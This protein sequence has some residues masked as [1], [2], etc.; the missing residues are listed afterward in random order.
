MKK[1]VS[2]SNLKGLLIFFVVF[3]HMLLAIRNFDSWIIPAIYSFHM[4]AFAFINGLLSKRVTIK[5]ILNLLILYVIFQLLICPFIYYSGYYPVEFN[6]L[7]PYYHLWYLLT[8]S[9]WYVFAF[10][11]TK[12][13]SIHNLKFT[14]F[15]YLFS[16][17][18]TLSIL[19]LALTIRYFANTWHFDTRMLSVNRTFVFF[20]FFILGFFLNLDRFLEFTKWCRSKKFI[21]ITI[22]IL[23][24]PIAFLIT[25]N[26]IVFEVLFYG[27]TPASS[28]SYDLN[29]YLI[30]MLF[31]YGLATLITFL[32]FLIISDKKSVF[33]KI[34]ENSMSIY[35]LHPFITLIFYKNFERFATMNQTFVL[36]ATAFVSFLICYL[37][38]NR[39]FVR[40]IQKLNFFKNR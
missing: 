20:P 29:N 7:Q 39:F 32:L 12:L 38:A 19:F 3:G 28:F 21:A 23:L 15:F 30:K 17:I 40:M 18:L 1:D 26:P 2:I 24:V 27:H 4:P 36:F 6:L 14:K 8:L 33:T 22:S 10:L 35:L 13:K 11:M 16:F 34:G 31:F 37:F 9:Y 25:K 5:K